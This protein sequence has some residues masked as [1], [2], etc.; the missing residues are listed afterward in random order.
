MGSLQIPS[1]ENVLYTNGYSSN[2][3]LSDILYIVIM[4]DGAA[5]HAVAIQSKHFQC[6]N[7]SEK[8]SI[9]KD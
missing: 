6:V 4:E 1:L 3:R 8:P 7:V 9:C 5:D 2:V